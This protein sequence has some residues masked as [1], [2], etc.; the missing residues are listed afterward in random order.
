MS[1]ETTWKQRLKGRIAQSLGEEIDVY[2]QQLDLRRR[3]GLAEQVFAETRLRRG[4]YGQ[5]YDNGRRHDGE[6]ERTIA[7]PQMPT[8]GPQTQW[9]APGMLRIK[10]PYGALSASQ[11]ETLADL[12]EEY[13]DAV[14]HATT[15]QDIQLH[16]VH[17]DD[18]PDLMRRLAAVGLTT[19]EACGNSVRNITGCHLAGVCPGEIFDIT[20]YAK[21]CAD[22]LL[23]HPDTQDFGR[24][25]K[26]AFSG[27]ESEACALAN[28]HDLAFVA[29]T[30]TIAGTRRRGFLVLAGGGLGA[31]PHPAKPLYEF[32]P[33][34]ELLPTCQAVARVFA[35]H[36]ERRNRARARLKFV[37]AKLG[38]DAFRALVQR[39]RRGLPKDF[40]WR[41]DSA[42]DTLSVKNAPRFDA[43]AT[44]TEGD[45]VET[46]S[47]ASRPPAFDRWR[48]DN[49]IAQ[50]QAGHHVVLVRL[51]LGDATAPQLRAL[52]D[53]LRR[54]SRDTLRITVD[55]NFALRWIQTADLGRVHQ[56]LDDAGLAKAGA[57]SLL[58]ITACPGT[59]TCKLGIASSRGLAAELT[60][61]I[62]QRTDHSA[63]ARGLRIK[64]SGCFNSC[65]QH[66][67]ADLGFYGVSRK[68]GS[69]VV[70][71]FQV[72]I[73]GQWAEN[74]G[75]YGLAIVAIPA[76]RIPQAVDRLLDNFEAG[77]HPGE[78][79]AAFVQRRG[80]A[81]LR[82]MLQPLTQ[83]PTYQQDASF[84][85]DWSDPR[86]YSLGDLGVGECAGQVVSTLDFGLAEAERILFQAQ[87]ELDRNNAKEA[88][89]LSD[90]AMLQAAQSLLSAREITAPDNVKSSG[91]YKAFRVHLVDTGLFTD[92]YAGRKFANYLHADA[93]VVAADL[94]SGRDAQDAA[95]QRIEEAQLFIEASHRC[96]SRIEQTAVKEAK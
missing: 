27:C 47:R 81:E 23:G 76:K 94:T 49:V 93:T 17:I 13:A 37:V 84:Y 75:R 9:H 14:V 31:V 18:T 15:R 58:D 5:R 52:A 74:G 41:L 29:R 86:E 56:A 85:S 28:I 3:G 32:L 62:E 30:Q 22:Y 25:F 8:K 66:H 10:V 95:R 4:V 61:R 92:P 21:A 80:K 34:A 67:I 16:F 24:K 38:I 89:R 88:Q 55:Q 68:V 40:R 36:G 71:H 90:S 57:S 63:A 43:S 60:R 20:P 70:P 83:V 69:H 51:A 78:S 33:V 73:G 12:S 53:I 11:L 48:S 87:L 19:R 26:I 91:I 1:P 59:D 54:Y 6:R 2:Q 45:P 35:K 39:E 50:R 79:F 82:A 77:R 64:I 42:S 7:Y 44:P 72:V 65:G 96:R 46:A